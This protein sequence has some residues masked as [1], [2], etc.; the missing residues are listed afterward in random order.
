MVTLWLPGLLGYFYAWARKRHLSELTDEDALLVAKI[1]RIE[2]AQVRR[3]NHRSWDIGHIEVC[4]ETRTLRIYVNGS[5][6]RIVHNGFEVMEYC[7]EILSKLRGLGY[8]WQ[9]PSSKLWA[10]AYRW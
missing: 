8:F 3:T 2:N 10:K 1:A 4:N 9:R 5:N 6:T 7:Y